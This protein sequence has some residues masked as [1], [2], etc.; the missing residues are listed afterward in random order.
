MLSELRLFRSQ[1]HLPGLPRGCQSVGR[2]AVIGARLG[3]RLRADQAFQQF[4]FHMAKLPS[5]LRHIALDVLQL[6]GVA[7][8]TAIE[9]LLR[10]RQLARRVPLLQLH[11]LLHG[12]AARQ[13]RFGLGQRLAGC[14]QRD[15]LPERLRD[16]GQ[17]A[18]QAIH[19]QVKRV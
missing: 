10:G 15:R 7:H 3:R 4:V 5:K 2:G 18:L 14:G 8:L 13:L 19:L 6:L 1:G 12:S 17:P 16:F 9:P 11:S